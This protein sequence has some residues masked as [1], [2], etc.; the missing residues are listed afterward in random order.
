MDE[1]DWLAHRFE[2]HRPYLHTVAVRMLGSAHEADDAVQ[3]AWLRLS[4]SDVSG[5]QDLGRW[6]T[7]VVGRVCLDVLRV[8]AARREELGDESIV[9][10]AESAAPGGGDPAQEA[11]L[12]DSVGLA[13]L[14]VLDTL[15]PAERVAFVLH[16]VF[17]V[18]HAEI[19][20]LVDRSVAA[21]KMLVSR[22]RRR[23][24]QA[25]TT[26]GSDTV[27]QR[28]AV[29]AF[30][31]AAR[32]GDFEA[33]LELLDSDVVFRADRVAR[34]AGAPEDLAG[35]SAVARQFRGR[36]RGAQPALIDGA[37][38]AV[39]APGGMPRGVF[40]FTM[41]GGRIVAIELIGDPDRLAG[42]ELAIL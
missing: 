42:L 28:D 14:V 19:A 20:P 39:W 23:V 35:A 33:L 37:V 11:V 6:L 41:A 1:R 13:L 24:R 7:T 16:D 40:V 26:A 31:V 27:R 22:A 9:K 10:T 25:G 17:A 4:R 12:S 8:R 3:E 34:Q 38:G 15:A 21:T 36:A 5:V 29:R 30:L 32:E 18:P 2:D